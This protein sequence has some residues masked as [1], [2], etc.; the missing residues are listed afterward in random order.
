M[1]GREAEIGYRGSDP[2]LINLS[3]PDLERVQSLY[4]ASLQYDGMVDRQHRIAKAHESTFRWVIEGEE[5]LDDP[6]PTCTWSDFRTWLES[7]EQ[8][9]WIT[10]KA[11]SGKSTLMKFLCS[12]TPETTDGAQPGSEPNGVHEQC[13][14]HPHLTHWSYPKKL[15]ILS[16]YFWNSGFEIQMT[17]AGLFRTLLHQVLERRPDIIPKIDPKHWEAL[18]LFNHIAVK[19]WPTQY[20]RELLIRAIKLLCVDSKICIFVDGLDEFGDSHEELIQTV[21]LWTDYS[22]HVKVCVASRPWNIFQDSLGKSPSMRL[23]DLT[24]DDI[25]KFVQSKFI[26]DTEFEDLK[27]RSPS[28]ANQ[29]MDNIVQKASGVFLWV[30]IVVTSL[31]AGMRLGDRIQDFQRRLDELPPDLEKLYEKILDSLDP[32]Y[33]QHAAQYFNLVET[34]KVPLTILQFSFADEETPDTAL[35]MLRGSMTEDVI[36]LR[37]KAMYRRLN[38]RCKG[39]LETD[40]ALQNVSP[41]TIVA[42]SHLTVQY[43]HRTVRDFIKSAKAQRFLQSSIDPGHDAS[44]QLC[45]AYHMDVKTHRRAPANAHLIDLFEDSSLAAKVVHCLRRAAGVR[46][47]GEGPMIELID[48]LRRVIKEPDFKQVLSENQA[49]HDRPTIQAIKMDDTTKAFGNALQLRKPQGADSKTDPRLFQLSTNFQK[50]KTWD[51]DAGASLAA[52][53]SFLSLAVRHGVVAYVWVKAASLDS[54]SRQLLF[55]LLVAL[56]CDVPEPK[57]IECLLD[58]GAD[59][60][61]RISDTGM[62]TPWTIALTKVSLLPTIQCIVESSADYPIAED[63]WKQT[64]RVMLAKG[65]YYTKTPKSLLTPISKRLLQEVR[66]E[67]DPDVRPTGD[68]EDEAGFGSWLSPWGSRRKSTQDGPPKREPV[69]LVPGMRSESERELKPLPRRPRFSRTET[70][71][72]LDE[73]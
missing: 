52:D 23:E 19:R 55:L 41:D 48:E 66:R 20:L 29:L 59:P 37:V 71:H 27:R 36:S 24:R 54:D 34:A 17:Q 64:L 42:P 56:S 26:A 31:L 28:F 1:L 2:G 6:L 33:L 32:F 62:Q 10:G 43:L 69:V 30:D 68:V 39:F 21:K 18:C 12:P 61:F 40:R 67:I 22:R 63:K 44:L 11:G 72:G 73:A 13:R 65:A 46:K 53:E 38:S 70:D 51:L 15:I 4:V 9:Y 3:S 45:I 50:T 35:R 57:M 47:A 58:L 60:N 5:S 25:K 8:L 14:C 7:S 16:F 49:I